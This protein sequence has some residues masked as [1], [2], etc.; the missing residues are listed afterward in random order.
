MPVATATALEAPTTA[1]T[2]A[3]TATGAALNTEAA[4]TVAS[5]T[6]TSTVSALAGLVAF[7]S[8][9]SGHYHIYVADPNSPDSP[10]DLTPGSAG[11]N[12]H[13]TWSPD[14][15]QIAFA[16]DP[17]GKFEIFVM[18]A[19]GSNA[20][21]LT[22]DGPNTQPAWSPDGSAILYT[23][24]LADGSLETFAMKADGTAA[25]TVTVVPDD[26]SPHWSP[27][28]KKIVL[29][30]N[31]EL[32][33][34][35]GTGEMFV[36]PSDAPGNPVR[37]TL[38]VENALNVDFSPDGQLLIFSGKPDPKG[39]FQIYTIHPDGTG[40]SKLSTVAANETYPAYA[41]D[42]KH[43]VFA[44]A[45]GGNNNIFVMNADGSSQQQLT[46]ASGDN[47]EPVW[48]PVP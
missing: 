35:K 37:V 21:P 39:N 34:L 5:G 46:H 12:R 1:A 38:T 27:D 42:G 47:I 17:S 45:R 4:T 13:P 16:S 31:R 41:P 44:S 30:T 18:N 2:A 43:I 19:D 8:D 28:G 22:H 36:K 26:F 15:K 20:T 40:T 25:R 33:S 29:V 32:K 6:E 14:G 7:A 9:R 23:H 11:A 48:Q 24:Q 10:K 3:E